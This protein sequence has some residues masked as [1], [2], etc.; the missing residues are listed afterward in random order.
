MPGWNRECPLGV[1]LTVYILTL[2]GPDSFLRAVVSIGRGG[3]DLRD[4]GVYSFLLSSNSNSQDISFYKSEYWIICNTISV[5]N[6]EKSWIWPI[7]VKI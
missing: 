5:N 7:F 6:R 3:S 2:A 1:P 4:F